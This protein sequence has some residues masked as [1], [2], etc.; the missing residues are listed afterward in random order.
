MKSIQRQYLE[1]HLGQVEAFLDGAPKLRRL[2][3]IGFEAKREEIRDELA[4]L[5]DDEASPIGCPSSR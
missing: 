4:S 5:K 1:A 2:E 3:R